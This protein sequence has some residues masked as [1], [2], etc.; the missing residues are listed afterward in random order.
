VRWLRPR[1]YTRSSR[2]VVCVC[3][4]RIYI[5][6]YNNNSSDFSVRRNRMGRN[7]LARETANAVGRNRK[8]GG[9]GGVHT[10]ILKIH[11]AYAYN[12]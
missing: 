9:G 12:V 11:P 4:V 5:I 1:T 6:L 7:R 8:K 2:I 10:I 3:V